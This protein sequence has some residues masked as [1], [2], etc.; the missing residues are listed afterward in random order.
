MSALVDT[1]Y[2]PGDPARHVLGKREEQPARVHAPQPPK[3]GP[4]LRTIHADV[5]LRMQQLEPVLAEYD[6]L[7][8]ALKALEGI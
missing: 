3:P 8:R 2:V 1:D 7:Q 5:Q 4:T 6:Q